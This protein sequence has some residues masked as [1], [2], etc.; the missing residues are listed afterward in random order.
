MLEKKATIEDNLVNLEA[1]KKET[2]RKSKF[3]DRKEMN[4]SKNKFENKCLEI[5]KN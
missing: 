3:D 5:K 4:K 1:A 2:S